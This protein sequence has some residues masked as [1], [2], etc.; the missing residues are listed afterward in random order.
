MSAVPPAGM[1][2]PDVWYV[3][4]RSKTLRAAPLAVTIQGR[5][6]VVF[7]GAGGAPAAFTDRCP[8]RNVPLSMGTVVGGELQCRYHGWR[9]DAAGQCTAVPGLVDGE[10][11]L[12]S[13]CAE[14]FA[15]V[16]QQGFVWVYSTPNQAPTHPPFSFPHLGEAPYSSVVREFH[17]EASVHAVVENTL[18]VPHTAYL[19]GGLFR[20]AQKSN[21]IDV[22]VRRHGTFAEAEFIGEPAPRGLVGRLLAPGGGVTEHTDRFL[23]PSIAQVEYRL[24][25]TSHLL[26]T[27]ALTPVT[28]TETRVFAVVTFKLPVPA[29]LV[30]PFVAPIATSI[31]AQ[32]AVMLRR[33]TAQLQRFGGARY[34]STELDVLGPQVT[35]LLKQAAAGEAPP[36]GVHEHRLRMKT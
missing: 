1:V 6:L 3:A 26:A 5:P 8:H 16:E 34:T 18:D 33:Q 27:S 17:V 4:C 9:F 10:V 15:C 36:E 32:D 2:L 29:W 21:V 19:H 23:L 30:K 24:G 11:S 28:D 22:V 20:T 14:A 35:R 13:R 31:F 12:R 25:A 7:R